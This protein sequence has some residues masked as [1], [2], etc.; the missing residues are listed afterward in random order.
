MTEA[1][2]VTHLGYLE[3]ERYRPESIGQTAA[4]TECRI[5]REDGSECDANEPGELV[6]KG[7]QFMQ[8]YWKNPEATTSALRDGWYFSGDIAVADEQGFFSIVDRRKELIKYKGLPIAPAEVEA[9]L[10]E[11]PEVRD[12]G[13]VGRADE[14][15]G[16]VP[17]AFVVPCSLEHCD[18]LHSA[19]PRYVAEHLSSFKQPREVRIIGSIPRNPSGK[20]LRKD[21]RA[22]L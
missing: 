9:V 17:I 6:M 21:L 3:A 12:C 20:I 13:V 15:C 22:L 1:S 16:E 10:L 4:A 5:L 8:G 7:A 19:L 11:H 18:G 14:Q 2:P